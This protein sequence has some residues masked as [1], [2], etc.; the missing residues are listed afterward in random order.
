[1]KRLC[2]PLLAALALVLAACESPEDKAERFYQSGMQ[3]LEAGDTER[4]LVEFR[5]VFQYNGFHKEARRVYADTVLARGDVADNEKMG[6]IRVAN[7]EREKSVKVAEARRELAALYPAE[8]E[9]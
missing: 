9:R 6:E 3:L 2:I 5:N 8:A 4:A 1:M 7:A